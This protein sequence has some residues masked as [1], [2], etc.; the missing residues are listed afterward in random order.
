MAYISKEEVAAL[1]EDPIEAFVELE[2]LVRVRLQNDLNRAPED[3]AGVYFHP[4]YHNYMSAVLPAAQYYRIAALAAWERPEKP[5]YETYTRFMDDVDY[6]ITDLKFA[7]ASRLQR[8]SVALD[9][10]TK[11]KLRHWLDQIRETV[12]L[13]DDPAK[14]DR[15]YSCI[16]ALQQE[17]DRDRTKFEA[18]G[19]LFILACQYVAEGAKQLE[20][21]VKL[22]ERVGAAI[23]IAKQ[24][25]DTQRRLPPPQKKITHEN[26]S[27]PKPAPKHV[28]SQKVFDKKTD[29]EIPF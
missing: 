9:A 20:P 5:G 3:A 29:D 1:P 16:N 12:D 21:A 22:I 24:T 17:I 13:L 7:L 18:V 8:R 27:P 23:G 11:K 14:K 4:Y 28:N 15:L 2:A 25:E 10:P 19:D 26:Q 6:C